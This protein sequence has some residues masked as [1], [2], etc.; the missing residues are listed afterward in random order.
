MVGGDEAFEH[1][2]RRMVYNYISTH[3]GASFG[4]IKKF[5][6]MNTSTLMYHLRFLERKQTIVSK[7]EGRHRRYYGT[8]KS[9][10]DTSLTI[11]P[12]ADINLLTQTQKRLI[13]LIRNKPGITKI[14]L[15]HKTK[16]NR[17]NIT[18]NLKKLIKLNFIWL[19]KRDDIL[20]YEFITR[21]KLREEMFN[22]L[23]LKLVANEIDEET[24]LKIKKKLQTMNIEDLIK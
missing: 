8:S 3:P 5:F 15:M 18:Y 7:R 24:Y 21:E 23:I 10:S 17:K 4:M 22:K 9:W 6:D 14:E 13:Y 20:G 12:R 11:I 1:R 2:T 16:I 19:V